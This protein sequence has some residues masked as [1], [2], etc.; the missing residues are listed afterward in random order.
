MSHLRWVAVVIVSALSLQAVANPL[1]QTNKS[2]LKTHR[3]DIS[4]TEFCRKARYDRETDVQ[5]EP[6]LI[7][8]TEPV[9]TNDQNLCFSPD[10]NL[11]FTANQEAQKI[12]GPH[13]P[14]YVKISTEFR[15]RV[16]EACKILGFQNDEVSR[17]YDHCV[18]SRF[19]ELMGPYE[20]RYRREA[21]SYIGKRREVAESLVVRCDAALSIK[22]SRLPR[23]LRFPIAYYDPNLNSVPRW[24]VEDKMD[25]NAWLASLDNLKVNDI[26]YEVLGNDCPGQMVYWVTYS[27]PH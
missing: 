22:R 16:Q 24:L 27:G 10:E 6:D 25:D 4:D 21:G 14:W 9:H 13:A 7:Q 17:A 15:A 23:E 2:P 18:E 8:G 5:K 1:A 11:L 3:M 20:D 19:E 12:L 26:M